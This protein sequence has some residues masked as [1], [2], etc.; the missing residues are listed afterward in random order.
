M[1]A[2]ITKEEA[3]YRFKKLNNQYITMDLSTYTNFTTKC[4]FAD[5]KYGDWWATPK[6]IIQQ[7]RTHRKRSIETSNKYK[8]IPAEIISKRIK[9]VH[10][11]DMVLD[12]TTYKGT[13]KKARFIDSEFGE[14]FSV[15]YHA[16]AGHSH[17]KRGLIK[18]H[19]KCI[20]PLEEIQR[21]IRIVHGDSIIIKPETYISAGKPAVFIHKN[22]GEWITTPDHVIEG[23]SHIKDS[24]QKKKMTWLK[25][26]GV[27]NPLKD[28]T[29]FNKIQK[30]CWNAHTIKH[31]K[32]NKPISCRASF[33]Y[34]VAITLNKNKIDYEWQIKF[35]LPDKSVYFCDLYL[36]DI[37]LYIEIKGVFK[38]VR[39][40]EKWELFHKTYTNSELWQIKEIREFTGK[41]HYV[42]TK[43]FKEV[44]SGKNII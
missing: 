33:E 31:W 23:T 32:T 41:S 9:E 38:T 15:V 18:F 37:D 28:A 14:F 25:N 4:R 13:H 7:K 6:S 34:A 24:E 35:T 17:P 3:L 22:H 19:N 30:S 26:Y 36:N 12:E 40:K 42:M 39:S 29:I 27:D 1:P 20:V 43:E 8:I 2:A 16:C 5:I 11:D 21:R 44:L 10:G